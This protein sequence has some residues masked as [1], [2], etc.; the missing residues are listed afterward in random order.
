[1]SIFMTDMWLLSAPIMPTL[2]SRKIMCTPSATIDLA[3]GR[4]SFE[5]WVCHAM[6]IFHIANLDSIHH[7]SLID[8]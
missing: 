6:G 7:S 5:C 3:G 2:C 8:L 1:M 4:M